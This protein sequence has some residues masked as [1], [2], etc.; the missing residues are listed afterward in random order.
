M[1]PPFKMNAFRIFAHEKIGFE[2]R[3]ISARSK[4]FQVRLSTWAKLGLIGVY[5]AIGTLKD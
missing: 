4:T 2:I 3:I 1:S 5:S